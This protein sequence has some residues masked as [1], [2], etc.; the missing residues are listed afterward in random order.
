LSR[1]LY[2]YKDELFYGHVEQVAHTVKLHTYIKE[3]AQ[4]HDFHQ[5]HHYFHSKEV[6]IFDVKAIDYPNKYHGDRFRLKY[7]DHFF[8]VSRSK[9]NL[10][11]IRTMSKRLS[12][13]YGMKWY[14]A[15]FGIKNVD[16]SELIPITEFADGS[17]A[18]YSAIV[19]EV[20]DRKRNQILIQADKNDLLASVT[21]NSNSLKK[22][23]NEWSK[24][25]K[26]YQRWVDRED[27]YIYGEE[28]Y[29]IAV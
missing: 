28:E 24:K 21:E 17:I 15:N 12:D 10:I 13:K 16:I 20:M 9:E 7:E 1:Y 6:D 2:E 29:P 26:Y 22:W 3:K 11:E 27:V 5:V 8:W 18:N 25:G 14:G 23:E 4:K 19:V